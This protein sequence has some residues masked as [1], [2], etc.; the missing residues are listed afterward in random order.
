[1]SDEGRCLWTRLVKFDFVL[2]TSVGLML[3]LFVV[4]TLAAVNKARKIGVAF[5]VDV[6][7]EGLLGTEMAQ[8]ERVRTSMVDQYS[9]EE[10]ATGARRLSNASSN[11]SGSSNSAG[12][13]S[14]SASTADN[15]T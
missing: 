4:F 10:I 14:N 8:V 6:A 11:S 2:C 15:S 13:S 12:L 9:S 1:M 5:K 7:A 3:G